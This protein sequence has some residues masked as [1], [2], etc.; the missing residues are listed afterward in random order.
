MGRFLAAKTREAQRC[1]KFA[2][3]QIRF[4]MADGWSEAERETCKS[5]ESWS[6]TLMRV[7][8]LQWQGDLG[9]DRETRTALLS[10]T[11]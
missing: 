11:R 6:R 1:G 10:E 9:H 2:V 5:T 7:V 3:C 8:S 4:L